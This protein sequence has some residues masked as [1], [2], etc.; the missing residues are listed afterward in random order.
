MTKINF[1]HFYLLLLKSN[2][3]T[4]SLAVRQPYN[5]VYNNG[6]E[7]YA[8]ETLRA[9]TQ[10]FHD[11]KARLTVYELGRSLGLPGRDQY[12]DPV[13]WPVYRKL[14]QHE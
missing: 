5:G 7:L 2:S 11:E 4:S 1:N 6:Q 14:K 13:T 10:H 12:G 3:V 9:V 8:C